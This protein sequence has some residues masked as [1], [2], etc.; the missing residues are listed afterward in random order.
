MLFPEESNDALRHHRPHIRDAL[1]LCFIRVHQIFQF[2]E[3]ACQI[4]RGRLTHIADA[5]RIDETRQ[6]GLSAVFDRLQQILG[7]LLAHAFQF[8][9]CLQ[10]QFVFVIQI[11]RCADDAAIHQL[12]HQLVAQTFDVQRAAA[13][14]MQQ[15]LLALRRAEQAAGAA[16]VRFAFLAH[17]RA[18]AYRAVTVQQPEQIEW[19]ARVRRALVEHHTHHFRDHVARAAHDHGVADAHILAPRLVLVVQ[20]RIADRRAADENR[21]QF[22]HRRK[23]A[24]APDLDVDAAHHGHLFFRREFVR[25]RPARLACHETELRLQAEAVDLVHHA[26]DVEWQLVAFLRDMAM[27]FHQ[28]LRAAHHCAHGAHRHAHLVQRIQQGAV[29]RGQFPAPHLAQAIREERQRTPRGERRIELAYAAR[30]AVARVHQRG[31]TLLPLLFVVALEVTARHVGLAAHFQHICIAAAQM[32]GDTMDGAHVLR[33]VLA[34]LAIAACGGLHQHAA[35]VAQ[36]DREAVEFQFAGILDHG[37]RFA[38]FA[39]HPRIERSCAF[40]ADIG[41]GAYRQHGHG[42]AHRCKS[43]QHL[44][45]DAL[46]RGIGC[47]EFGMLRFKSLQFAEQLV[48]FRVGDQRLVQHVILVVVLLDFRAQLRDA[49]G[50]THQEN[51]LRA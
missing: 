28:P 12:L 24:G 33:H 8:G 4:F 47:G 29:R 19:L 51:N 38:Q 37:I 1:Q 31:Q 2:P 32:Q 30:R 17:D 15:G 46:R 42:M 44:A 36:V 43:I 26:I 3:M 10:I 23:L 11:G 13:G 7:R 21:L 45:A 40:I 50:D 6:R 48:V 39:A 9:Q 16:P 41:L 25:H 49:G 20:R 35:L 18:A 14:K 34:S 27:K 5:E 22:R